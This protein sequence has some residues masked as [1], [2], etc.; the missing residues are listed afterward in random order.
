MMIALIGLNAN[1]AMYIVGD[2]PFGGWNP[3][4]GVEMTLDN[5]VYTY[6][7]TITAAVRGSYLDT[8]WTPTGMFSTQLPFWP[9]QW[10]RD[11]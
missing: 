11:R 9:H 6:K 7:A 4:A 10:Q 3:G 5:G 8:I 2:A 1:A